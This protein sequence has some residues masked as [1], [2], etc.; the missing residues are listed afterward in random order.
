MSLVKY[1]FMLVDNFLIP[2]ISEINQEFVIFLQNCLHCLG[3]LDREGS[4]NSM[5]DWSNTGC[6]RLTCYVQKD[7]CQLALQYGVQ[8]LEQGTNYSFKNGNNYLCA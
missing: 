8:T 5:P 1:F 7:S 4:S 3:T 6:P 2:Q